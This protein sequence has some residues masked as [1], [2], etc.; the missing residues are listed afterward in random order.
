M[1][2][3]RLKPNAEWP[4]LADGDLV[5]TVCAHLCK[6]RLR[7]GI[8]HSSEEHLP[9]YNVLFGDGDIAVFDGDQLVLA[10]VAH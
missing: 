10:T 9:I 8:I 2:Q 5:I 6:W 1:T 4:D 7:R 3:N